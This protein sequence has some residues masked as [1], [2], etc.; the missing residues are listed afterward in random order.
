MVSHYATNTNVQLLISLLKAHGIKRIITS[1]GFTHVEFLGSIQNDKWFEIYSCIDERGAAYMA[2]GMAAETKEPVVITCTE[3]TAS[4]N[5]IPGLT[6]AYYRK[7]PVLA[8]TGLHAYNLIGNLEPQVIDRSVSPKD[9]LVEKVE[10]VEIRSDDDYWDSELKINKALLALRR[11][12]GGPAHINLPRSSSNYD[13]SVETPAVGRV[14]NR[15]SYNDTLPELPS[16][17]IGIV[18]WSHVRWSHEQEEIISE[19]CENHNAVVFCDHTS[20]YHGKYLFSPSLVA[21]QRIS[22]S[23]FEPDL[24]INIGEGSGDYSVMRKFSSKADVWRVN[25][26]GEIRDPLKKIVK[27]FQMK[28]E[29]FFQYY[30]DK[31]T[32]RNHDYYQECLSIDR[33]IRAEIPELPFSN[34]YVAKETTPRLP[35]HSVIHLGMSNTIRAWSNFAFPQTVES[36]VNVGC[37]GIDGTLSSLIGASIVK[38]DKLHFGVLGDLSFFYDLN[39]LGN[40]DIKNNL[41]I[42]VINNNGGALFKKNTGTESKWFSFEEIGMYIAASKHF[43]GRDSDV[44]RHYAIDLGFEYMQASNKDE[45]KQSIDRFVSPEP[46]EKP[47]I[48][49]IRTTDENEAKAFELMGNLV[50]DNRNKLKQVVK[51]V[52]GADGVNYA[53]KLFGQEKKAADFS[54]SKK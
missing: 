36:Y 4:R 43:G 21:G 53:K 15:Y 11:N 50:M 5:Y 6:E 33:K 42:I 14:I 27:V 54:V 37:R 7:L 40:R 20:G 16:G 32:N 51:G 22:T 12:G 1:P 31:K 49:E 26:D 41:R 52:I 47:I 8:I 30:K 9:T 13:F 17:R 2:C 3:A 28:E 23:I 24:I 39:S 10:L 34:M 45:F 46:M 19:F 35:D 38:K 29:D 48:F 44:I 18:C 25:P